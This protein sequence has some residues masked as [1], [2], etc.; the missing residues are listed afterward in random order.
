MGV[1]IARRSPI[2]ATL[3]LALIVALVQ[4]TLVPAPFAQPVGDDDD[5]PSVAPTAHAGKPVPF[6]RDWL[7]PFFQHGAA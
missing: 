3:S 7:E 2:A 4:L 5:A 1:P 6:D